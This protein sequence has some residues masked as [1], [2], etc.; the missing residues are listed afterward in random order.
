[1]SP[2]D[3][4]VQP[5]PDY[6]TLPF[7]EVFDPL[8]NESCILPQKIK[9]ERI[10]QD[11]HRNYHTQTG[12]LSCGGGKIN[13]TDINQSEMINNM[14]LDM[15]STCIFYL[16]GKGY[17]HAYNLTERRYRHS[18]WKLKSGEILLLGGHFSPTTTEKLTSGYSQKAFPLHQPVE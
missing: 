17:V 7:I 16:P 18:S 8:K 3:Q 2:H 12:L 13:I 4:H 5:K 10:M 11:F 15:P 6:M 14:S 9:L 1:M